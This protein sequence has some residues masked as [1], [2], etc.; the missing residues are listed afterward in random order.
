MSLNSS[1]AAPTATDPETLPAPPSDDPIVRERAR[2]RRTGIV[3]AAAVVVA[4]AWALWPMRT[5]RI[6]TPDLPTQRHE[7]KVPPEV[8][9]AS[10]FDVPLWTITPPPEPTPPPPAPPPPP[11][12]KLQLLGISSDPAAPGSFRAALFDPEANRVLVAARGDTVAGRTVAAIDAGAVRFV[13]GSTVQ[14][15]SLSEERR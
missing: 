11:P 6:A 10:A 5:V 4:A 3:G 1:T 2:T 13:A 7:V 12:L 8:L 9:A 14:T 15:L